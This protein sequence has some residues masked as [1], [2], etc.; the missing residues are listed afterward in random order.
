MVH[1][2]ALT[3]DIETEIYFGN[4]V[5]SS[6]ILRNIYVCFGAMLYRQEI[7]NRFALHDLIF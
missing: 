6:V 4:W 7:N 2:F 5:Q 3:S 1:F